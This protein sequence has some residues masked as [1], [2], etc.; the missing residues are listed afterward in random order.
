VTNCQTSKEFLRAIK[1]RT[2]SWQQQKKLCTKVGHSK[3]YDARIDVNIG[4]GH[5]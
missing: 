3:Q 2:K 4:V 1:Q 5:M